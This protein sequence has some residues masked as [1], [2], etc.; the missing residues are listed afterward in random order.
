MFCNL[1]G[2]PTCG[3]ASQSVTSSAR[4]HWAAHMGDKEEGVFARSQAYRSLRTLTKF[5]SGKEK[6]KVGVKW[7]CVPPISEQYFWCY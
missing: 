1:S 7:K 2:C 4:Q 5:Y 3:R 6:T